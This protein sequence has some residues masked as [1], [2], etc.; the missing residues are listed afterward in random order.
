MDS[1][2]QL[3][4]NRVLPLQLLVHLLKRLIVNG[5]VLLQGESVLV[6]LLLSQLPLLL[7]VYQ[8]LLLLRYLR[9]LGIL[10]QQISLQLLLPVLQLSRMLL[11]ELHVLLHTAYVSLI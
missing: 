9:Q 2:L 6:F 1:L 8:P 11:L 5:S 4:Y 10:L 7:L 3:V